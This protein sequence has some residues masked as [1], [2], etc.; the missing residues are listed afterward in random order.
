[1]QGIRLQGHELKV[2]NFLAPIPKQ[3]GGG[4][5]ALVSE[6]SRA[7]RRRLLTMFNRFD[8]KN[9][10][11][12]FLTLTF[13]LFPSFLEAK[14]ALKRFVAKLRYHYGTICAVWRMEL[15]DRGSIHFHLLFFDLP[16]IPQDV[17]QTE[18]TRSTRETRSIVDVRLVKNHKVM[19]KYVSK[20]VAKKVSVPSA[21]SLDIGTY[22]QKTDTPQSTGRW[23]G[24]INKELLPFAPV[25]VCVYE[26]SDAIDYLKWSMYGIS[27]SHAKRHAFVCTLWHDDVAKM[28]DYLSK[29][30]PAPPN[31]IEDI[32][33]N[34]SDL[35]LCAR[36]RLNNFFGKPF[37]SVV[38]FVF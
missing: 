28:Y 29:I 24:I 18:W 21:P 34:L 6:F 16:Y 1:M 25:S 8:V 30:S 14:A 37:M 7:S 23:W 27:N 20:Y 12:T 19:M 9:R 36:S 22:S 15:Q 31:Y 35:A 2:S 11:V 10:K 33:H 3:V 5:R 4:K 13:S 38:K 32:S 17:L 26:D